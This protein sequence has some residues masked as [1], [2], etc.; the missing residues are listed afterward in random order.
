MAEMPDNYK[1]QRLWIEVT[2]LRRAHSYSQIR[3]LYIDSIKSGI[4]SLDWP[5]RNDLESG[6]LCRFFLAFRD[7][8]LIDKERNNYKP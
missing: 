7:A 1:L 8:D 2:K 3:T 6:V 5:P 4:L